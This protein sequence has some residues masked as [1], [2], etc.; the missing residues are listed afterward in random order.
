VPVIND[1]SRVMENI[2]FLL[3][4]PLGNCTISVFCRENNHLKGSPFDL[5]ILDEP[6][7]DYAGLANSPLHRVKS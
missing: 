5:V 4:Q 3:S 7:G 2:P 1:P 6:S